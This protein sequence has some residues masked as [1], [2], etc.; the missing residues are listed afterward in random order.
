MLGLKISLV[1]FK[2]TIDAFNQLDGSVKAGVDA[3]TM[4]V[5][6]ADVLALAWTNLNGLSG[7]LFLL[8]ADCGYGLG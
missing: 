8:G 7:H 3:L 2:V 6:E 1:V 5:F 4:S